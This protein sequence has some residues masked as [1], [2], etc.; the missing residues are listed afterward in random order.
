MPAPKNPNTAKATATVIRRGDETAAARLR[1]HG[2]IAIPPEQVA[3]LPAEILNQ[4]RNG[5]P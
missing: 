3:E 1:G 5:T 2:W 4:L